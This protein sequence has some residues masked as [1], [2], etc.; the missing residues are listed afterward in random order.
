MIN[1]TN[2][3]LLNLFE[4]IIRWGK[5]NAWKNELYRPLFP[6]RTQIRFTFDPRTNTGHYR[7]KYNV[8]EVM[9]EIPLLKMP[10]D[11]LGNMCSSCYDSSTTEAVIIFKDDTPNVRIFDIMWIANMLEKYIS[12]IFHSEIYHEDEHTR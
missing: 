10:H 6:E 5:K 3:P 12:R 4:R 9:K 7:L 1:R 8:A 11:F 2:N